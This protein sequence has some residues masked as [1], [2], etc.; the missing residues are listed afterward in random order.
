MNYLQKLL[1]NLQKEALSHADD[2]Y[3]FA[4][5][6]AWN[7]FGFSKTRILRNGQ[8][9]VNPYEFYL[10]TFSHLFYNEKQELKKPIP[11]QKDW[12]SKACIYSLHIRSVGAWDHDR[13][14]SLEGNLYHLKDHGTFVK[15]MLLLPMYK[16]MG[17]N[18]ILLHQPFALGRSQSSHAYANKECMMDFRMTADELRDPLIPQMTASEQ[19]RAFIEACHQL[20]MRVILE[21][22]PGKVSVDHL[23]AKTNPECFYWVDPEKLDDY[24]AP[25]CLNLPRNTIPHDYT[26]KDLYH[27][28]DVV[29]HIQRFVLP[30]AEKKELAPAFSDQINANLPPDWDA[31]YFRFYQDTHKLVPNELKKDTAPYITQDIIRAD[32]H[33]GKQATPLL[34]EELISNILWYQDVLQVD[35]IYLQKPYLLPEKLQKDMAKQ[36]K[37]H[38]KG[39]V[40][41]A[42]ESVAQRSEEWLKKGYDM[43]SGNSAYEES[44][45]QEFKFHSFAYRLKGNDC[46]LFA[47]SE[48]YDSRR[49]SCLPQGE[50]MHDLLAVMNQFLP[51][52]I[53]M[54]MSGME[55][56]DVQPMQ[57]SEY[58]DQAYTYG[59]PKE[60]IRYRKQSYI[61]HYYYD[62]CTPRLSSFLV[63]MEKINKLRTAYIDAIIDPQRAIPVWFDSPNDAGIGFTYLKEDKAMMVVCH[64]NVYQ[65]ASLHIHTENLLSQLSFPVTH[66]HQIYSTNDPY[67][68]EIQMDMFQNIPSEFAPGEVKFIEFS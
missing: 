67:T 11:L 63:L 4:I 35:G 13:D 10:Y 29:Q 56:Y 18:T 46:P 5:P 20:G 39:F 19:L 58:G 15:A 34:W 36:A 47:A 44:L 27:S 8:I 55:T 21:Y 57:L 48:F 42:E 17:V 50:I 49:V 2:I 41:I 51:N 65:S 1:I 45:L 62:Y 23:S 24:H 40:M 25:Q 54:Y 61:D 3:N 22:C 59:L 52:G 38:K 64:T 33:P 6:Q 43:I 30:T 60:D 26:L 66:V 12:L 16:R 9:L 14:D 31:T 68:H 32:L 28:E 7:L 53:P 37:K